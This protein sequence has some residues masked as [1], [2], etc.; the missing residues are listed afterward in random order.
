VTGALPSR[1]ELVEAGLYDP[2]APDADEHLHHL[3]VIAAR[4]GTVE[5]MLGAQRRGAID[6]LA[7]ELLFLP[8]GRRYTAQGLA[9]RAGVEIDAV[10]DLRRACGLPDLADEDAR[11]TDGDVGVLQAVEAASAL[12]GGPP[13]CSCCG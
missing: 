1:E 13:R 9:E 3:R 12:F 5:D 6:R 7:A 4:G 8:P 2:G 10:R 11:Y